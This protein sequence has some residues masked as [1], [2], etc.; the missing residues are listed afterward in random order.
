MW[1]HRVGSGAGSCPTDPCRP[2][3]TIHPARNFLVQPLCPQ[4][5]HPVRRGELLPTCRA[6]RCPIHESLDTAN[7]ISGIYSVEPCFLTTSRVWCA[8][9]IMAVGGIFSIVW[10]QSPVSDGGPSQGSPCRCRG[11][12]DTWPRGLSGQQRVPRPLRSATAAWAPST[13]SSPPRN[14]SG[15]STLAH[16]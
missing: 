3:R 6:D 2:R 1:N 7:K 9:K 5:P 4:K 16:S 15:A 14:P 13:A 10:P 11:S 8:S 12:L